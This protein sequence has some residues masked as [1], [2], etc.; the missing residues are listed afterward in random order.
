[1]QYIAGVAHAQE[2]ILSVMMQGIAIGMENLSLAMI[3]MFVTI[4][5]TLVLVVINN[6]VKRMHNPHLAVSVPEVLV[7]GLHSPIIVV[8]LIQNVHLIKFALGI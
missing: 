5:L 2:I 7:L 3:I 8:F 6:H 4:I 1:M